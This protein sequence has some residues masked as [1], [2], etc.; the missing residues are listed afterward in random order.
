MD[1]L[2][3]SLAG[4][5]YFSKLDLSNAYLQIE[6]EEE[7]KKLVTINTPKGLF[8]YNRLPFGISSAP[9]IFQRC[10]ETLLQGCDG[11]SV[12]IDDILV[13][14]STVEEHLQNLD[15]VLAILSTAGIKLNRDK[16]AFLLP[17]VEYLGH[18]IDGQGLHPTEEK[19]K[20][21]KDAPR[22]KNVSELRA[23]L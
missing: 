5:R 14:G 3:A 7:L 2:F 21:I 17:Q 22:P 6:L 12:Y 4:G 23:F 8:Q 16:C 11:T 20:A 18:V 9:A 1:E 15:R 13:S 19:V 10:M